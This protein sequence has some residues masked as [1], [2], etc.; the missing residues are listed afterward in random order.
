MG[1]T[2]KT[3]LENENKRIKNR[4]QVFGLLFVLGFIYLGMTDVFQFVIGIKISAFI[5]VFPLQR[6]H[7]ENGLKRFLLSKIV[8][9]RY[10]LVVME[11]TGN[12]EIL[13]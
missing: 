13:P 5:V 7:V 8:Y 11:N 12:L 10:K 3:L 2:E 6:G 9:H 4:S 1:H